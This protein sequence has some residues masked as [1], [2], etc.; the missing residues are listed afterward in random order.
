[1]I[2]AVADVAEQ[3]IVERLG[4]SHDHP[5]IALRLVHELNRFAEFQTHILAHAVATNIRTILQA[6]AADT[7]TAGAELISVCFADLVGFTSLGERMAPVELGRLADRL[8][9]LTTD[10]VRP[11]VRFI[12]TLGDAV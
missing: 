3:L 10:I 5:E 8:D 7:P 11:P 6:D 12:K 4:D 2:W 1:N 9:T